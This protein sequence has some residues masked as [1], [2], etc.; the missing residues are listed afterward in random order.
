[1]PNISSEAMKGGQGQGDLP[2][3]WAGRP[4]ALAEDTPLDGQLGRLQCQRHAVVSE[5]P[6]A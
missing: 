4:T 3:F 6:W 5:A 2:S 1:M